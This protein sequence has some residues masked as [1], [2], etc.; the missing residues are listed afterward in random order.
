MKRGRKPTWQQKIARERIQ[1]LF[2]LAE[3]ELDKHPERSRRYIELARKIGMRYNIRLPKELKRKF[4]KSCNSL[5]IPGR[6]AK[7]RLERK[8]KTIAIYCLKCKKIYRYPWRS[9][10]RPS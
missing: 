7:V 4:C 9:N 5:L 6:T 8:R 2:Y 3:K 10:E 1:I